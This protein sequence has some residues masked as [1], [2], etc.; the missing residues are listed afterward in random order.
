METENKNH[1][2]N[3]E[4]EGLD[5]SPSESWGDYPLDTVFVRK[6]PRTVI[7][8]VSR[9][10]KGR[11]KLDPEFQ[12]DFVWS[13]TK[14]SRLIESSLMRI[15][16]PVLYVAEDTD[17]RIIVVDGLQ[18]LTTFQRYLNNEFAL[19][20]VGSSDPD[21][22]ISGK[23]FD[24][25]PLHLQE[26]IEDTQLT[27][28]ILDPK[29]P[30][31][32]RLDIF[33]RVNSGEPLTRQQ[34]RNC[35]YSGK[36]TQWLK[37][38]SKMKCFINA[39]GHS[40][41]SKSMRDREV[42][43]RF[44]AFYILGF[45]SYKGDMEEFLAE[46][47]SRMNSMN[48][49]D[50]ENMQIIFSKTME[51]NLNLFGKHSFRK[52]ILNGNEFSARSVLNISLFDALSVQTSLNYTF[53]QSISP[54]VVKER[55]NK[56]LKYAKFN[57][58]ISYSTNNTIEAKGRH[59]LAHLVL[60]AAS[61]LTFEEIIYTDIIEEFFKTKSQYISHDDAIKISQE[62]DTLLKELT[63]LTDW[64]IKD[65]IQSELEFKLIVSFGS[66]SL[67]TEESTLLTSK[68]IRQAK[69]FN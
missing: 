6:E 22:I 9:I 17:G 51:Y 63:Q 3:D 44:C 13:L 69:T 57:S 16:L 24:E 30:E 68:L 42:I 60:S 31:R 40:L 7:E 55:V 4:L 64:K 45:E 2:L 11:Y 41:K 59:H 49:V 20:D 56:L 58:A 46:A 14:Q 12:R 1:D 23:K 65:D 36:S 48:D 10:N 47:L 5:D 67:T 38:A 15:P 50:L 19:K 34:M 37:D 28:Y 62:F 52:S 8:I 18:R 61:N 21:S 33:E 66:T 43:N 26:R 53:L 35:L 54:E 39:T 25:L 32:A 27:L 29:A